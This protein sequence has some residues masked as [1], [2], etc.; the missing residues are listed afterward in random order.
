MTETAGSYRQ[1]EWGYSFFK[2]QDSTSIK[3]SGLHLTLEPDTLRGDAELLGSLN[4]YDK[5][6][7]CRHDS[8][9][10]EGPHFKQYATVKP[11]NPE[12]FQL[13]AAI[14][15][16]QQAGTQ[17]MGW[18]RKGAATAVKRAKDFIHFGI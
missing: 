3:S 2:V 9:G 12:V 17:F 7:L 11:F 15:G 6:H 10:E 4:G 14:T 18:L 1:Q 16:A 13:S 8:C 5:V